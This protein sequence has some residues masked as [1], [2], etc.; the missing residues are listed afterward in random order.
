MLRIFIFILKIIVFIF[1]V[2]RYAV[3]KLNLYGSCGDI[4]SMLTNLPFVIFVWLPSF[5]R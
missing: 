1:T 3:I 2:Y 4:Q 5:I